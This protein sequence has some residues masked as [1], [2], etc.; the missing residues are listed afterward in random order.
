[1][2]YPLIKATVEKLIFGGQALA[3]VDRKVVFTWN[4][5]PDETVEITPT[6][7]KKNFAE[8]IAT[9]IFTPSLHRIAP[10]ED[11]YL[12]CS[13]WQIMDWETENIWKR[14]I[15]QETY[16]K[17]GKFTRVDIEILGN[18]HAQYEYRNKMEYSFTTDITGA[19]TIGSFE[20]GTHYV[21]PISYCK[22]AYPCI[23]EATK[24]VI[25][26]L[27]ENHI[28]A[29]ALKTIVLR[30]NRANQVVALL[31]IK[32]HITL[33]EPPVLN[34]P[35]IG[36]HIYFSN[37]QSP[38]SNP[39]ELLLSAGALSLT[40]QIN[41]KQLQYGA[42]SFF[43]IN[44]TLFERALADI[45]AFVPPDS[46]VVD[47][48]GGVGAISL[49]LPQFK[50]CTIVEQN[51]EAVEYAN[52]NIQNNSIANATAV[53]APSE[54]ALEYITRD[55]VVIL[56][57]PRVGLHS[58][59]IKQILSAQPS[60]IVYLSCNIATQARDL[61]LLKETY[62]IESLKLYNFFPRTPHIEGLALLTL[63]YTGQN[64]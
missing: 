64:P 34:N 50:S 4:A 19:V 54:Q 35:L 36:F 17:I 53:A 7:Q 21:R 2:D 46:C 32:E 42:L 16:E 5:L 51:T 56:D 3:R 25:A 63:K 57:P 52:L 31:F 55:A 10:Q 9:K 6:K 47:L 38:A 26:W 33:P 1:M 8:G 24:H 44:P 20:R 23:N 40:E 12:S 58:K 60:H 43:Q 30:A 27:N 29:S 28:K 14:K 49:L 15:A 22:L 61:E 13:P 62:A 59:I 18:E 45:I 37:P 48:Y 41:H 39:D 11:H